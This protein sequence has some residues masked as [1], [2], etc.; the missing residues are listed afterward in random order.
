[1][2]YFNNKTINSFSA[3]P[4]ILFLIDSIG[5]FLTSF[6]LFVILK[7]FSEYFGMPPIILS[8]LSAIAAVFCFYSISCFLFLKKNWTIFIKVIVIANVLY[9]ML[10]FGLVLFYYRQLTIIEIAYFIGEIVI[11]FTLVGLELA[12][13]NTIKNK[14]NV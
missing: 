1:V 5:A 3:K 10:T 14:G 6:F 13:A 8:Y 12:V 11:V 2:N 4:K 9:C 7:H